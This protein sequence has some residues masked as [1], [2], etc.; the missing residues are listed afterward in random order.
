MA[1]QSFRATLTH[2][3][4]AEI[5]EI[6]AYWTERDEP[7]RGEQYAHDLP[8]EAIRQLAGPGTARAG[9]FLCHTAHPTD[10]GASRLQ[11][12]LSHPLFRE[13]IRRHRRSSAF[14]ARPSRRAVP[15]VSGKPPAHDPN[16]PGKISVSPHLT[17]VEGWQPERKV[18]KLILELQK[19]GRL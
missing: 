6:V 9:R 19:E 4:W 5:G 11:A 7:G 15:G 16:W 17:G 2:S 18:L 14:L 1:A 3:A 8:A 12:L 10:A 13:G